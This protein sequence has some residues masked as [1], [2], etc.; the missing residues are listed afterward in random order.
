MFLV[1][2]GGRLVGLPLVHIVETMRPLPVDLLQGLPDFV[3]GVAIIRGAA[4]PVIELGRLLEGQESGGAEAR[5]VVVRTGDRRVA[6][7]VDAVLGLHDP[8]PLGALS[9]LLRD[10]NRDVVVGVGVVDAQLLVV[11]DAAR[12]VP[13]DVWRVLAR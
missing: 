1:R 11:L 4:T 3:A 10:A 7:A 9:P 12:V 5:F 13:A 8:G 6:L 2:V